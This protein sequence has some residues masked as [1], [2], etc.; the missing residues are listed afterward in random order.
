MENGDN[1][2][3]D[4]LCRMI[5][6]HPDKKLAITDVEAHNNL[7][8]MPPKVQSKEIQPALPRSEKMNY[9]NTRFDQNIMEAEQHKN[10]K[11]FLDSIAVDIDTKALSTPFLL[12]ILD[13]DSFS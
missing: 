9:A 1:L 5:L 8:F 12:G 7:F 2:E 13:S 3:K 4:N 6:P 10:A 11:K